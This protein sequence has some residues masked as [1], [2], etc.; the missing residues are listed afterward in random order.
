[1]KTIDASSLKAFGEQ[2]LEAYGASA[3]NAGIIA[4]H[5]VRNDLKGI[6]SQGAMRFFEYAGFMQRG[7]VD[8]AA[9]PEIREPAPGAF[10][11]DGKGGF[12]IVALQLA[13]EQMIERMKTVP[14]CAAGIY[15]VGHTGRIGDFA[16]NFAKAYCF[17]MVFGGGGHKAHRT[18]APFGGTKG[19]MSTNP[20][21]MAMPGMDEVP[22][23]ADFATSASAG[24]K[25]RLAKRKG[26]SL[27]QGHIL[28][29]NGEPSTNPDDFFNGG[30]MLPS[31][32]PKGSGMGMINELLTYG[33]FGN[34]LE[35]NWFM[36]SVKLSVFCEKKEYSARA[37]EF[38]TEVD[39]V[40]PAKGFKR[41][42]YPGQFEADTEKQRQKDGIS[43][44]DAIAE[45]LVTM[46]KE[47]DLLIPDALL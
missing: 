5:L 13:S 34:P 32:G 20:I 22:L 45:K 16:E 12:G 44:S 47:K 35:F 39:N 1:M 15:N 14:M 2:F 28:D 38:L 25:L 31:A 36:T 41:V 23:S 17:G 30:V 18:V 7:Q 9:V 6:E 40:P 37:D 46:A 43:V 10:L 27:P 19:I 33:L 29:K 21:A 11:V 8:G 24:G 26:V 3:K 42:R 4:S